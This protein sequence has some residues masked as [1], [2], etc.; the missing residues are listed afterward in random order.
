MA[1][2]DL[3]LQKLHDG[4]LDPAE[5]KALRAELS[6]EERQKLLALAAL[7]EA[8]EQSVEGALREAE[9]EQPLDLWAAIAPQLPAQADVPATGAAP[10]DV[11]PITAG[12]GA[13][14]WRR[15]RF[16]LRATAV[17]SALA[18]AAS[19]LLWL[20]TGPTASNRCDVEELEVAGT[21]AAL[22]TLPGERGNDTTL[23]W[24]DHDDNDE[25]E[26]L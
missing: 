26:S 10:A 8:I 24:V 22:I 25:W 5:A 12:I 14:G 17:M 6:D 16:A 7:D 1:S 11:V 18:M 3:I 15:R 4:E 9:G 19:L 2:R 23:I 20:R 13:A 21:T